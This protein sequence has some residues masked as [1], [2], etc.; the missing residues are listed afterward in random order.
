MRKLTVFLLYN[1]ELSTTTTLSKKLIVL[2]LKF[3]N[4]G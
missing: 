3:R 4:D 2:M 1:V